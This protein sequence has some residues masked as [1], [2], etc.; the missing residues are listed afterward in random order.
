[1]VDAMEIHKPETA[2]Q[3]FRQVTLGTQTE[4]YD[5]LQKQE[6]LNLKETP[7]EDINSNTPI[8][9][10]SFGLTQ[11]KDMR[12]RQKGRRKAN[13]EIPEKAT[14]T[15]PH[16]WTI[17][18]SAQATWILNHH[19]RAITSA[20]DVDSHVLEVLDLSTLNLAAVQDEDPDLQ[21]IKELLRDHNVRPPWDIV[22]EKSAE[23]KIL[24]IQFHWLKIQE[25]VLYRR[26]K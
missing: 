5:S 19:L 17:L 9:I 23:V 1:M 14:R 10:T 22:R 6:T 16:L 21:F 24:W 11:P 2:I 18:P 12:V 4:S 7:H 8:V 13:P 15:E 20:E 3:M 26:R 25:N